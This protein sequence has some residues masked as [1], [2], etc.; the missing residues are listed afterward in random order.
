M[1]PAF[2]LADELEELQHQDELQFQSGHKYNTASLGDEFEEVHN[3]E[4]GSSLDAELEGLHLH[5]NDL[6][7]EFGGGGSLADELGGGN[8]AAE[9][10]PHFGSGGGAAEASLADQLNHDE[11][12]SR[13]PSSSSSSSY[14][15][16]SYNSGVTSPTLS[17]RHGTLSR[18]SMSDHGT[19]SPSR[20]K[21]STSTLADPTAAIS[22]LASSQTTE[23]QTS[24]Q[25]TKQFLAHLSSLSSKSAAADTYAS[26]VEEGDTARL[27]IAAGGYLKLVSE[28][29]AEREAQ[30]RELRELDRKF[31]RT[32]V[33]NPGGG[34]S[35]PSSGSFGSDLGMFSPMTT[36]TSQLAD[37]PEEQDRDA[38]DQN[39]MLE[40][41]TR[42]ISRRHRSNAS[43]RSDITITDMAPVTPTH[44]SLHQ[45][46]TLDASLFAPFYTSTNALVS[47]LTNLHEHTQITK[48]TSA[49]A[50]RKLKTLKGLIST[51]RMEQESVEQSEAWIAEHH[52]G[53]REEEEGGEEGGK[54]SGKVGKAWTEEQLGWCR[55]RIEQVE[56]RARE[57]LT[58]VS[59]A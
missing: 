1:D 9:L 49:D 27:E 5:G 31:A 28:C 47:S 55:K 23:I 32:F 24:L 35:L 58:P 36:S 40:S 18:A 37:L 17:S 50:Q 41:P 19:A 2:S 10:D 56:V 25:Q 13:D 3:H 20:K 39:S 12:M 33:D 48:S 38:F 42:S 8:L 14:H 53:S 34:F 51:W 57:L 4:F 22:A 16:S 26:S 45:T 43:I 54:T 6:A 11:G 59:I 44:T 29:T 46:D 30:L 15:P 52:T 21:P 7:S